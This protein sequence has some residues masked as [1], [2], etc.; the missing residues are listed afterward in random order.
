M[1][2][3]KNVAAILLAAGTSSRMG[4]ENKLL[5]KIAGKTILQWSVENVL[6]SKVTQGFVV[7]GKGFEEVQSYLSQFEVTVVHNS[8]YQSGISASLKAGLKMVA[9]STDGALILLAD[10]PNLQPQTLN[11][12][13]ELFS[14]G[15]KKI[16]AGQYDPITGNPVLFHRKYFND[17]WQLQGDVG[18]RSLLKRFPGEIA[19]VEIPPEQ[20]L[21]IDTPED[22]SKMRTILESRVA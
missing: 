10:Q 12:F 11:C 3:Q 13:L 5:L 16:I 18:A 19:T 9:S 1:N 4:K 21:D 14:D 8:N 2:S 15:D 7:A 6:A 20:S 22:F 17:L